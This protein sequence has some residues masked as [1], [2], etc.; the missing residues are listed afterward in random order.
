MYIIF[1]TPYIQP[2]RILKKTQFLNQFHPCLCTI[3]NYDGNV[4]IHF[5]SPFVTGVVTLQIEE[6]E[7]EKHCSSKTYQTLQITRT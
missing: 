3:P 4:L 1:F 2:N 5:I 7:D 6:T